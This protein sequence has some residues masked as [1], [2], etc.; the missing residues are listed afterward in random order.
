MPKIKT[1]IWALLLCGS[2]FSMIRPAAAQT[3]PPSLALKDAIIVAEDAMAKTK[4]DMSGHYI[5][6]VIYTNSSEGQ[7]WL[8]TYKTAV[9][10]VSQEILVKVYMNGRTEFS[11][12]Y[13]LRRGGY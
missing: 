3:P 7:F 13:F 12:G 8:F 10:T 1:L 9:P 6:S 5:Y 4:I 11:G 2:F